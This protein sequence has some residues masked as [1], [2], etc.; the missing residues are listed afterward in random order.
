MANQYQIYEASLTGMCN[1]YR[2]AN[3]SEEPIAFGDLANKIRNY[4]KDPIYP[5]GCSIINGL[6]WGGRSCSVHPLSEKPSGANKISI[7]GSAEAY[8]YKD[9]S[10]NQFHIYTDSPLFLSRYNTRSFSESNI[11]IPSIMNVKYYRG[12][13]TTEGNLYS[14]YNSINTMAYTNLRSLQHGSLN[15]QEIEW[16][17]N[18]SKLHYF[19]RGGGNTPILPRYAKWLVWWYGS[20]ANDVSLNF[21]STVSYGYYGSL[22]GGNIT[23]QSPYFIGNGVLDQ[24]YNKIN[25]KCCDNIIYSP[26]VEN[27]FNYYGNNILSIEGLNNIYLMSPRNKFNIGGYLPPINKTINIRGHN[28]QPIVFNYPYHAYIFNC[29]PTPDS[30]FYLNIQDDIYLKENVSIGSFTYQ[31]SNSTVRDGSFKNI[32]GLGYI[33]FNGFTYTNKSNLEYGSFIENIKT[34]TSLYLNVTHESPVQNKLKTASLTINGIAYAGNYLEFYCYGPFFSTDGYKLRCYAENRIYVFLGSNSQP[35]STIRGDFY[36]WANT[37]NNCGM[38]LECN[39]LTSKYNI[40]IRRN[41]FG[42]Y[43]ASSWSQGPEYI[44]LYGGNYGNGYVSYFVRV[45]D[46]HYVEKNYGAVHIY[47][48][49]TCP[50]EVNK[51]FPNDF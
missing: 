16:V 51:E 8:C 29:Q 4:H 12:G 48:Y 6:D 49:D 38:H 20:Y 18:N 22:P 47:E 36:F 10:T 41:S 13:F 50:F 40:H 35:N 39:V 2:M 15:E 32:Y 23:I 43:N 21:P 27:A 45:G 26:T 42:P 46:G 24:I 19:D 14:I 5:A 28:N 25:L 1:M 37:M 33:R 34:K 7:D 17:K 31:T 3:D 44:Y 9:S 30:N 11:D